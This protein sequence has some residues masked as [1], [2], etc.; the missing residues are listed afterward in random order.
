MNIPFNFESQNLPGATMNRY[1]VVH[2]KGHVASPAVR[3]LV[4]REAIAA[5][6]RLVPS[7]DRDIGLVWQQPESK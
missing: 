2:Y 7:G 1:G 4:L 5:G 6:C 3:G